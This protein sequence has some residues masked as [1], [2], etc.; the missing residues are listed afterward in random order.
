VV[1]YLGL[2]AV[3]AAAAT[4]CAL[5]AQRITGRLSGVAK[6]ALALSATAVGLA[7]VLAIYG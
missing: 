2:N 4:Y 7:V 6:V 1:F 3:L 5:V